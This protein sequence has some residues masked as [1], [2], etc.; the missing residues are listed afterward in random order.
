MGA[1][2]GKPNPR[3]EDTRLRGLVIKQVRREEHNCWL[4]KKPVEKWRYMLPG[5]HGPRCK[6]GVDGNK[7]C[8]GCKPDPW[9]GEVDE[10]IPVSRGG[11]PFDRSNCHL[12]HRICNLRRGNKPVDSPKVQAMEPLVTS[13]KW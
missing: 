13:R 2:R 1:S 10:I 9:R 4:C 8:S 12:A 3:R 7:P 6:G 5:Q 11:S